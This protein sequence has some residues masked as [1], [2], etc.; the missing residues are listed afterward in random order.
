[1]QPFERK[2][3][4]HRRKHWQCCCLNTS[5]SHAMRHI[6]CCA[7]GSALLA[8]CG[9]DATP[10]SPTTIAPAVVNP[11]SVTDTWEGTLAVGATRFYSY[12]VGLNGTVN[13]TLESLGG[14]QVDE[15]T[16][17]SL[18]NGYPS[19]TGCLVSS[20]SDTKPAAEPQLSTTLAPGVYCVK[21]TDAGTLSAPVSFRILIAHP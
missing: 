4:Q 12:S 19:G 13:V 17:V 21:L 1:M 16:Q 15:N 10:T 6:V 14:A 18:G 11:P 5:D 7:L 20:S 8:G 2:P 9:G 3:A